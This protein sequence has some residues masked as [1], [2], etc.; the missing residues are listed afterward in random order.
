MVLY[1]PL[2]DDVVSKPGKPWYAAQPGGEN[3][4]ATMVKSMF[5]KM[6]VSGKCSKLEFQEKIVQERT[7][8]RSTEALRMYERTTTTQHMAVARVLCAGNDENCAYNSSVSRAP[9]M[10]GYYVQGM[11]KIV[12]ITVQSPGLLLSRMMQLLV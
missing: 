3:K 4:L 12:L 1:E 8:H 2:G 7:G 11:M 10:Q 6:G 9:A 5:A